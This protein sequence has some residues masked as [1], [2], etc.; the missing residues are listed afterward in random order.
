MGELV[1]AGEVALIIRR[2]GFVAPGSK[3]LPF[4]PLPRHE[5]M[6]CD[7]SECLA[8]PVLIA[9]DAAASGRNVT[10]QT[11]PVFSLAETLRSER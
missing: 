8:S 2:C 4:F 1:R 6:F 7:Y 3:S 10:A 5:L 9:E 11:V